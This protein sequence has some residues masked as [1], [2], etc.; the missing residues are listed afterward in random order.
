MALVFTWP[1]S[2]IKS[3]PG[4]GLEGKG[5]PLPD[6]WRTE[7]FLA[8]DFKHLFAVIFQSFFSIYI[9]LYMIRSDY[10]PLLKNGMMIPGIGWMSFMFYQYFLIGL[11]VSWSPWWLGLRWWSV[12]ALQIRS[13]TPCELMLGRHQCDRTLDLWDPLVFDL[14]RKCRYPIFLKNACFFCELASPRFLDFPALGQN[15]RP[16][17][18]IIFRVTA[19]R[20][21]Q[22]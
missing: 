13:P 8:S 22:A 15:V 9:W 18:W 14:F 7:Q 1:S 4:W 12:P 21:V 6:A 20:W 11:Q 16:T 5:G 3:A 17:L 2:P 19:S 10:A